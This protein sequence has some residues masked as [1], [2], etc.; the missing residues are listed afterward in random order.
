[1]EITNS[2]VQQWTTGRKTKT[3]SS[4]WISSNAVC[5]TNRG[6]SRDKRK[7]GGIHTTGDGGVTYSCFNCGF[8]ASFHPGSPLTRNM[9]LWLGWV[10]FDEWQILKMTNLAI[11]V[12]HEEYYHH[13]KTNNY[14]MTVFY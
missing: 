10:G 12:G 5:C 4:G 3:S 9:K 11:Q 2:I 14:R 7:R 13:L 1:M 6:Y 8:K